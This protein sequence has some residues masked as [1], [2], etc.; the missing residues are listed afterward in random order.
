LN[1]V[2]SLPVLVAAAIEGGNALTI[3]RFN[4]AFRFDL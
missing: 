1:A 4:D 3:Q 2:L